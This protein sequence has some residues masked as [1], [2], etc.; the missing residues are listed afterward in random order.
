MLLFL[1]SSSA[2]EFPFFCCLLHISLNRTFYSTGE[3]CGSNFV[4]VSKKTFSAFGFPHMRCG[5]HDIR[6]PRKP[7]FGSVARPTVCSWYRAAFAP[8]RTFGFFSPCAVWSA[9]FQ[10]RFV[11]PYPSKFSLAS[12]IKYFSHNVLQLRM[13]VTFNQYGCR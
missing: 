3:S 1:F 9:P 4:N 6:L 5:V 2:I 12:F 11:F 7:L 8:A 13:I 10:R